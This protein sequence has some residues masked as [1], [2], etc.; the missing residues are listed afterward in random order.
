MYPFFDHLSFHFS[1]SFHFIQN[2]ALRTPLRNFE[3]LWPFLCVSEVGER[4]LFISVSA[5]QIETT[6]WSTSSQSSG[7]PQS[8]SFAQCRAMPSSHPV[9]K[10]FLLRDSFDFGETDTYDK[11]D[12]HACF[13]CHLPPV[14]FVCV[15]GLFFALCL[16]WW[17][18]V[19]RRPTTIDADN[20]GGGT[21][22][23]HS[24]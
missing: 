15:L 23:P 14:L 6:C 20:A 7:A 2:I 24:Q 17:R 21:K 13:A 18:S 19:P 9:S 22:G 4:L 3:C 8:G 10:S 12:Q 11:L 16:L 5:G 1:V